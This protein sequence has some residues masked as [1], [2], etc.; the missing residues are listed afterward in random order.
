[1]TNSYIAIDIETTGLTA[2]KD[3][4]TEIAALRVEEGEI[5]GRF[6]TLIN[7][8][9]PLSEEVIRLTGITVEMVSAA[10]PVGEVIGDLKQFCQGLPLLG[11]NI[12]FDYAFLKQAAAES[13]LDFEAEAVDT[14]SLCRLFMP[15][16]L[17]KNLESAC[18]YFGVKQEGAHRAMA[19]ALSAHLLYQKLLAGHGQENQDAFGAKPLIYQVKKAQPATKR[20]KEYLQDLIKYH[21]INITVQMDS[22]TRSEA[23]RMIDRII[24]QYGRMAKIKE[25]NVQ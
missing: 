17:R 10:P 3:K 9:C 15:E 7:P 19:D 25:V 2:G 11:H 22:L 1:M 21:R 12:P 6:G 13:G 23:S 5:T 18:A 14:L 4:I 8:G 20:Q 24:S 16:G